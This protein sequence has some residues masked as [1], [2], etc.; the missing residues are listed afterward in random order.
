M[1]LW[2]QQ[3]YSSDRM[4]LHK[5]IVNFMYLLLCNLLGHSDNFIVLSGT[6]AVL[7]MCNYVVNMQLL[8]KT[9]RTVYFITKPLSGCSLYIGSNFLKI[10][11]GTIATPI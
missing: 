5:I 7:C 6:H 9:H 4:L 2:L 1:V 10:A 11:S 3:S 8:H